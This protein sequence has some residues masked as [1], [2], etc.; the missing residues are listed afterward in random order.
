MW[1]E[2]NTFDNKLEIIKFSH[3]IEDMMGDITERNFNQNI[4]IISPVSR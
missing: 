3:W 1:A 2:F 4:K